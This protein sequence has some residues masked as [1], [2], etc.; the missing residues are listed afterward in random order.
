MSLAIIEA[1]AGFILQDMGFN[2]VNIF[3]NMFREQLVV[4]SFTWYS[5][6]QEHIHI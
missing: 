2:D 3:V 1:Q 5:T 4:C 6:A